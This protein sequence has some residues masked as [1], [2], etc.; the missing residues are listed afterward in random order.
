MLFFQLD[1]P[2]KAIVFIDRIENV[3]QFLKM[4]KK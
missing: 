2:P 1:M 3:T 4:L